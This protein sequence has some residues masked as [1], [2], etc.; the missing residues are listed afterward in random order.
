V[1]G[2]ASAVANSKVGKA[3][4][5][6]VKAEAAKVGHVLGEAAS[7]VADSTLGRLASAAGHQLAAVGSVTAHAIQTGANAVS[8]SVREGLKAEDTASQKPGGIVGSIA[9]SVT[10]GWHNLISAW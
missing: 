10:T 7:A 2:A 4:G 5:A 1:E 9:S 8:G 6:E 3:V